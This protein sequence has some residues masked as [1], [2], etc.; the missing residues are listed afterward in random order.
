MSIAGSL[1]SRTTQETLLLAPCRG[2][3]GD[4][5][6]CRDWLHDWEPE[7]R[8]RVSPSQWCASAAEPPTSGCAGQ[9][10]RDLEAAVW[11]QMVCRA[12]RCI[13]TSW[14]IVVPGAARFR[15]QERT[16]R[17]RETGTHT[18]RASTSPTQRLLQIARGLLQK[19]YLIYLI[20]NKAL[21]MQEI[22]LPVE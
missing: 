3:R 5:A 16:D 12:L 18:A 20:P 15:G 8:P 6:P 7:Q 14:A 10:H 11:C 17:L 9:L 13:T 22:V 2:R 21:T 1:V 19:I 4:A